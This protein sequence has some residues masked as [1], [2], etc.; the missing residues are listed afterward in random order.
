MACE[1]VKSVPSY[2]FPHPAPPR[3]PQI[4]AEYHLTPHE[5]M[6]VN[7]RYFI[8]PTTDDQGTF[9]TRSGHVYDKYEQKHILFLTQA[10]WYLA[11]VIGQATHIWVCRTTTLS[12]FTHGVFTNWYT[13]IGVVIAI[14]LGCFVVY[15]PPL[16][17][18]V[19]TANPPSLVL[20]YCALISWG[21]LWT[22]SEGRKYFTRNYPSH[23]LNNYLAW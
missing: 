7:N 9:T 14:G 15:L 19:T 20:F 18:V 23:W 2:L 21:A 11:L 10:G 8:Y 22:W 4:F 5:V 13:N 3:P 1:E 17:H 6:T 16:Q 12:I